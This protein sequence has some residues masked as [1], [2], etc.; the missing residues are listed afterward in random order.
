MEE[1]DLK[2]LFNIFWNKKWLIILVTLI[3]GIAGV[4][5]TLGFK[6]PVYSAKTTLVL[7]TSK[8]QEDAGVNSITTTDLTLNSKLVGTYSKLAKS[9]KVVRKV[10][11][12]LN[13]EEDEE[14]IRNNIS[15]TS[16]EDTDVIRITV[17]HENAA[18][19][20]K[21][22]N[23]VAKEFSKVVNEIYKI[24]NV[25]LVDEAE[26]PDRPSN[27]HHKKDV[28]LFAFVGLAISAAYVFILNMLDTTV[29]TSED[30]EK[31]F[32]LPVL[33]TI[34]QI[35]SFENEKGGKK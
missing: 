27:V 3:F 6:T 10:L 11:S 26:I 29:K 35:D 32:G 21:I 31:E 1:I 4:V 22:A 25:Y 9:N 14:R 28:A 2:E 16:E 24:D 19:S 34:P 33:V 30:I 7:A 23:E 5:Y 13:L 18:Y 8:S 12:T 15:V 20:A 17:T